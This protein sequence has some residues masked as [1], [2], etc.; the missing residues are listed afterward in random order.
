MDT[1]TNNEMAKE[2]CEKAGVDLLPWK[3]L[4]ARD[5]REASGAL[6][7]GGLMIE[8]LISQLPRMLT[9]SQLRR[10]HDANHALASK[11]E[12]ANV[13]ES[14]DAAFLW[15]E[16]WMKILIEAKSGWNN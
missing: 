10:G 9:E 12:T 7:C 8:S 4:G 13:H 6:I 1:R 3:T 2:W 5:L 16:A 15:G 11:M 14:L